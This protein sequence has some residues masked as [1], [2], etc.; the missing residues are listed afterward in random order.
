[1]IV[2]R[3]VL[4]DHYVEDE[5][6]VVMVDDSVLG[7]SPIA[8]AILEAVPEGSAVSL[9]AVTEHVVAT[10]GPPEA[11]RSAM[12]L[13][14]QQ[15]WDLVAHHV[16]AV[17]NDQYCDDERSSSCEGQP[18][19]RSADEREAAVSALRDALRSL[20]SDPPGH[21]TAPQSLSASA[22]I[23]AAR[24]HHVIPHLASHLDRLD[25]P[26][27]AAS[28]IEVAAGRQRAGAGVLASDLAA[29]LSALRRAGVRAIAFKGVA[30]A[31][32]A[33]GDFA[34]RGAGDLDLLVAPAD[35]G[36]AH[37]ALGAAGWRPPP[38]FPL[39]GPSWAWGHLVRT[40]HELTMSGDRSEIDLHWYLMPTHGA[41][42]DFDTLWNRR[43]VVLV[44]GQAVPT[45]SRYDALAH[46]AGHAAKDEWRWMRSLV[47]V[48][49]LMGDPATWI[50]ADRP[51]RADQLLSIGVAARQLGTP[52]GVPAVVRQAA[53][54]VDSAMLA[55]VAR[56]QNGA[57][58]RHRSF[59]V[60]GIN[61]LRSLSGMSL[62]HAS[63]VEA[64]RL[65]STSVLPP[66]LTGDLT[67]PYAVVA[68][69]RTFLRRVK[70][71]VRKYRT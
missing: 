22:L 13:T 21:W 51:L 39:P 4:T 46:S 67:S 70:Q 10:F 36:R 58:S 59:P 60:P 20:R 50:H 56:N 32:Q 14:L 66:W 7:L 37:E 11:P 6:S 57:E 61:F 35:A 33:Y 44:D 26:A 16:L 1:M 55:R 27:R 24:R 42:P 3:G 62:T 17:V 34:A 30:L 54:E 47:D 5:R 23:H 43:D 64:A 12:D 68:V 19:D 52:S 2:R 18:A 63:P 25:L 29:A 53:N 8:T 38:G 49:T 9:E 65:V 28:E 69:P 71:V 31:A 15:V 48:H 41:F 45:F 40:S